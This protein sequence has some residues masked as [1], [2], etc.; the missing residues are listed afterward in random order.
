MTGDGSPSDPHAP[1]GGP[2]SAGPTRRRPASVSERSRGGAV[3][4]DG[5]PSAPSP[6]G[7][8]QQLILALV[9]PAFVVLAGVVY[10]ADDALARALDVALG[11]RL[12]TTALT[13]ASIL[14]P[15][16]LLLERG[17]DDLRTKRA[18]EKKLQ[19]LARAGSAE[20]ILVVRLE[21]SEI[22]IDSAG[23][24]AVGAEYVRAPF[25]RAELEAVARGDSA[26]SVLFE[27][28]D[29]RRYKSGYAPLRETPAEDE[30]EGP[31]RAAVVVHAPASFFDVLGR[32]RTI[33]VA[34]AAVGFTVLLI[35]A[36]VS[37]RGVTEPLAQLSRAAQRIGQGEL[38]TPIPGGGPREAVVLSDT[39][40]SMA[41]SIA[42]REEE[43]QVML[44]GIAHEVRNPLSGIELFGGILKEDLEEGDPRRRS[45][46]KILKQIGVLSGVVNDFLDFARKRPLDRRSLDV[47]TLLEEIA[48]VLRSDAGAK[49]V[50]LVVEAEPGLCSSLDRDPI[51]RAFLNLAKNAVQAV[52]QGGH[53]RLVA[54][55][56]GGDR[57]EVRVVDDGPGIP[58][59]A[60]ENVFRPF[61]TTKQKGTGLGLALVKKA[62]DAHG[63]TLGIEDSPGGGATFVVILPRAPDDSGV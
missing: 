50:E 15:K 1:R 41:R 30:G 51:V 62:V 26:A 27:G 38:D 2:G 25:D 37:A 10:F 9:V 22:L 53:V 14:D 6:R 35:L 16:I 28:P 46:D 58:A 42:H 49:D 54:R 55:A 45:V 20:R 18:A 12:T 23:V 52:P 31:V 5:S 59:E 8:R 56:Q 43:L 29:G 24:L 34:L 21:S 3:R 36:N 7:L 57:V 32:V 60:R 19:A 44:A 40:R 47:R 33:L 63:G 39:M 48:G 17:D 61:F 11:E 13:A 4:D